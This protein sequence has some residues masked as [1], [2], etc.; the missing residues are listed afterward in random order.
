MSNQPLAPHDESLPRLEPR[1]P[2]AHKGSFGTALLVGGSLGMSGAVSLAGMSALRGGAGLVRLAVPDLC[3]PM[4]AA[5]AAAYMTVGVASD[6]R[7]RIALDARPRIAALTQAATVVACGPGLS[8]S[9]GLDVL[10]GWLYRTLRQPLVVDADALNALAARPETLAAPGGPRILTPHP[11]EFARLA[12]AKLDPTQ[13]EARAVEL[14][15]AWRVVL[16]LKGHQT[17]VTD[18]RRRWINHTGNPG[19]A[20]GG[21]GDVL[22]GLTAALACQGLEPYDAAR[23]AVHVHGL[24]GDLAAAQLGQVALTASDLVQFLPVALLQTHRDAV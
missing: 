22:T 24:A 3:L 15:A 1:A 18:G 5:H 11:G 10:V 17:L 20:T 6:R 12:G 8:R 9:L 23:L 21:S 7:G 2:D 16:V 19:M 4:V 13:R 14:A